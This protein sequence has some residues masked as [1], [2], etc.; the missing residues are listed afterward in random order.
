MNIWALIL[1]WSN[2]LYNFRENLAQVIRAGQGVIDNPVYISDLGAAL[3]AGEP[4]ELQKV[5]EETNVSTCEPYQVKKMDGYVR[6]KCCVSY[7]IGV[8]T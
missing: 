4:V 8:S 6:Q 5:I 1:T 7:I 3:T 2:A